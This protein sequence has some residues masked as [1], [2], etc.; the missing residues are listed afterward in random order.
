MWRFAALAVLLVFGVALL[1]DD[2]P[3]EKP[4]D[5]AKDV[6]KDDEYFELFTQLEREGRVTF[7]DKPSYEFGH[8]S[9]D[10][11]VGDFG[12]FQSAI[13]VQVLGNDSGIIYFE[14]RHPQYS[15]RTTATVYVTGVSMKGQTDNK[16]FVNEPG[17]L[18]VY[19]TYSY[20]ATS[21]AKKTI[22]A[23]K[24]LDKKALDKAFDKYVAKRKPEVEAAAAAQ[25]LIDEKARKA[26]Q[27]KR[28]DDARAEKEKAEQE[29]KAK[30][31][32]KREAD[33]ETKLK[34]AK[35][36]KDNGDIDKAKERLKE[37]IKDYAGTKA[38][39]E[40]DELLKKW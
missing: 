12:E 14:R 7:G 25:K 34:G 2:K 27:R 21:L 13:V 22:F 17:A 38:A 32:A 26:A 23:L 39:K 35:F 36:F 28:E 16:P 31:E 10:L 20:T 19:G 3:K 6:K 9:G 37:I 18:I 33:A 15:P 4:K 40:A 5:A 30:R 11:K 8:L 1:S 24:P 29:A